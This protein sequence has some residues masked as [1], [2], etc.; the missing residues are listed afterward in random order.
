MDKQ[1]D[2]RIQEITGTQDFKFQRLKE[3]RSWQEGPLHTLLI[4]R[5]WWN[6]SWE[7]AWDLT[8]WIQRSSM[9]AL[10]QS[11]VAVS[12]RS[13]LVT[14]QNIWF[15]WHPQWW[16]MVS[17]HWAIVVTIVHF[18]IFSIYDHSRLATGGWSVQ[19]MKI[20]YVPIKKP[21]KEQ[22]SMSIWVCSTV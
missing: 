13:T 8:Q 11:Y 3:A 5:A 10:A 22:A 1:E 2:C 15:W 7:A 9:C 6:L 17:Q 21:E 20:P 12:A 19:V 4:C 16:E 18:V 14:M